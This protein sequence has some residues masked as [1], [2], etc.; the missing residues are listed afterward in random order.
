MQKVYQESEPELP[1][2]PHYNDKGK[3]LLQL[4]DKAS[5]ELSVLEV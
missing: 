4:R 5:S 1:M 2:T 3:Q